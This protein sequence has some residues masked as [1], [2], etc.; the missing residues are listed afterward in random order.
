LPLLVELEQPFRHAEGGLGPIERLA[1]EERVGF[2]HDIERKRLEAAQ[3]RLVVV[4][5][6]RD[7][8]RCRLDRGRL[9]KE[10]LRRDD[11]DVLPVA[12]P[13]GAPRLLA[14]EKDAVDGR[15]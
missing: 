6:L 15:P 13:R 10:A 3:E 5:L 2:L 9:M 12:G 4:A 11:S 8:L 7:N 1:R 14:R